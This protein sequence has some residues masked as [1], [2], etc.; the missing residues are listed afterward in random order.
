MI[1]VTEAAGL[2]AKIVENETGALMVFGIF[3]LGFLCITFPLGLLTTYL[4][5]KWMVKR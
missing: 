5:H 4:S 3:A 2:M 1:G